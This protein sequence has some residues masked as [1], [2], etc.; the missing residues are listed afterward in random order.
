MEQ[1]EILEYSCSKCNAKVQA[2]E[3]V[4]SNCGADLSEEIIFG[5]YNKT[6]HRVIFYYLITPLI[7]TIFLLIDSFDEVLLNFVSIS[8][9]GFFNQ[10]IIYLPILVSSV[11]FVFLFIEKNKNK[12]I[13]IGSLLTITTIIIYILIQ[14]NFGLW[15][16][17]FSTFAILGEIG[18]NILYKKTYKVLF[19]SSIIFLVWFFVIRVKTF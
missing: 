2:N 18:Y 10:I 14:P 3:E 17:I 15:T 12:R 7:F 19:A 1:K 13:I 11:L 8:I 16:A 9:W 5:K 4:C 6:F